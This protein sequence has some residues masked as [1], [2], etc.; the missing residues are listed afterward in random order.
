MQ[1]QTP[2]I[3]LLFVNN[4][5]THARKGVA[6]TRSVT[7]FHGEVDL[8][9]C[10]TKKATF[11]NDAGKGKLNSMLAIFLGLTT[12]HSS[13]QPTA[14][15]A[16]EASATSTEGL[17]LFRQNA[18]GNLAILTVANYRYHEVLRTWLDSVD[19]VGKV[20][21]YVTV[22]CIDTELRNA[23]Q[24][25]GR[26]CHYDPAWSSVGFN[27]SYSSVAAVRFRVISQLLMAGE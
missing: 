12:Y 8:Y 21:K 26:R 17:A 15:T 25:T 16:A 1:L 4:I 22:V 20:S 11:L 14:I 24:A 23:L 19:K 10:L 13:G 6:S 18:L 2:Q 27:A 7:R 5:N 3:H 9:P